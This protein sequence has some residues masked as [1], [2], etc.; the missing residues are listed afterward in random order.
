MHTHAHSLSAKAV[1]CLNVQ[2]YVCTYVNMHVAHTHTHAE[3]ERERRA[4]V[5]DNSDAMCLAIFIVC[6][7]CL[8][9]FFLHTNT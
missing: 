1:T 7:P 9:A 3:S 2:T 4:C 5:C 8:P 6:L